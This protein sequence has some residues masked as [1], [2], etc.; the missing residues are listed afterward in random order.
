MANELGKPEKSEAAPNADTNP[1]R[2]PSQLSHRI[3]TGP[4]TSE[5]KER[6]KRNATKHGIF[7]TVVVQK[8][9]SSSIEYESLRNGLWEFY[10]PESA[11]EEILVDKLVSLF[12]R[13]RKLLIAERAE[14]QKNDLFVTDIFANAVPTSA[15]MELLIR[16]E[17]SLERSIDRTLAQLERLQRMRQGQPVAPRI[18]VSVSP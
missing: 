10:Q 16:Y 2:V 11:L 4:R 15:T 5:G 18:D 13:Y 14:F 6:S 1:T 9:E 7:S 12:W 8:G 3:G 17:A